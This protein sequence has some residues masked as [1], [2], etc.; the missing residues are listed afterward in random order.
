MTRSTRF[1]RTAITTAALALSVV[2]AANAS[3]VA[4]TRGDDT[5][6]VCPPITRTGTYRIEIQR[7]GREPKFAL[8]V[9]ERASGCMSALIVTENGPSPLDITA[10]SERSLTANM[11]TGRKTATVT[12]RFGES[13]VS[14][15]VV[16]SK[17]KYVVKGERTS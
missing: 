9:L 16:Q 5:P 6:L 13:T 15:E 11:R 2:P 12:L 3:T 14:G 10:V 4:P 1:I 17:A 8:L 7:E